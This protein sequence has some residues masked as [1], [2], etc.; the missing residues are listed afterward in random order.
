MSYSISEALTP[1]DSTKVLFKELYVGGAGDVVIKN[2]ESASA[3]TYT[4]VPA[5]TTIKIRG[6]RLMA[7]TTA[8]G[9]V[10]HR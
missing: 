3:V 6:V 9:V 8:T 5:G 2:D 4:A 10:G 1:N 7:A